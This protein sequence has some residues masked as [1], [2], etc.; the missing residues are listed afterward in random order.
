MDLQRRNYEELSVCWWSFGVNILLGLIKIFVGSVAISPVLV[1]DGFHSLA[2]SGTDIF[3]LLA[4]VFGSR[5]RDSSHPYGHGKIETLFSSFLGV[6]LFLLGIRIVLWSVGILGRE[7]VQGSYGY[8][9]MLIA[10][11]SAVVKELLYRYV[12]KKSKQ[13]DSRALFANAWHHRS[14]ALSSLIAC[15][16]I[17]G[18]YLGY[19]FLDASAAI[20]VGI[21]ISA[22]AMKIIIDTG[23]ELVETSVGEPLLKRIREIVLSH[24]QVISTHR[25]IARKVGKMLVIELHIVVDPCITVLDSHAIANGVECVMRAQ[26][27]HI[28]DVIIHVDPFQDEEEFNR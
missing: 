20:V 21:L 3:V 28:Q 12:V 23:R 22:M 16:G 13:F 18:T 17:A 11:I 1:A 9:L 7:W 19:S 15:I 27:T 5:P 26:I 2:D 8:S 14:D 24:S 10:L 4:L 25:T 6:A